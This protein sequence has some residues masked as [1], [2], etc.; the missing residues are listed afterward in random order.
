MVTFPEQEQDGDEILNR[1]LR[2]VAE[3]EHF[4]DKGVL[5]T[6][7]GYV[8]DYQLFNDSDVIETKRGFADLEYEWKFSQNSTLMAG[9]TGTYIVPDVWSYEEDLS[10]WRS[11]VFVSFRQ[12]LLENWTINLNGRKTFVPF[13]NTP[14]APSLSTNYRIPKENS[15]M[16]IRGQIERSFRVPTFNDR[17]WG[18]QGRK[19]LNSENGYSY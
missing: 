8:W 19:D 16:V 2:I 15:V 17:Y 13:T 10:E 1:N 9:G 3:Y 7:A 18:E 5:S 11:D 14:I 12:I 4:F 6:A